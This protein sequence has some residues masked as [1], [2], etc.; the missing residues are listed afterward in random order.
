MIILTGV[1]SHFPHIIAASL[2]HQ[3]EKTSKEQNLIPRL[4]AGGFSDIT[5][6]AS[7]SPT[8]WR[9]I[10][11]QNRDVLL[12]ATSRWKEEMEVVVNMLED[13]DDTKIYQYF[14]KAKKFRDELPQHQ[15]GA[16]PAFYDLIC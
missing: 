14:E 10:L 4:A 3:A 6:I 11:L 13:E 1:I 9:D 8:M 2:V 5:R 12:E 7:S 16:I 15:S